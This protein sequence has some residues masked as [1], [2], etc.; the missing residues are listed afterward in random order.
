M[1][2]D[3]VGAPCL[4]LQ[5][6]ESAAI[7]PLQY[8]VAGAGALPVGPHF[9]GQEGA[10][11]AADGGVDDPRPR[12]RRSLAHRQVIP[13]EG[14]GV[15]SLLQHLLGVGVLGHHQQAAGAL[16]QPVDRVKVGGQPP[17]VVIMDQKITQSIRKVAVARVDQHAGGLV[18]DDEILVLVYDVQGPGGGEDA[19]A[20]LQIPHQHRQHLPGPSG[21]VG[22]GRLPVQGNAIGEPLG[23]A[24]QGARE[25][26]A[27]PQEEIHL[28]P[29]Q[30]RG[31]REGEAA[32]R[33]GHSLRS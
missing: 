11:Q 27:A 10:G 1:D 7:C 32:G 5:G 30:V 29:G 17:G 16:V 15:E 12:L 31:H 21:V 4:Q 3:L 23:P 33:R 13:A 9:P 24:D 28:P 26:Q 22:V 14:G 8:P 2:P 18:E 6:Q 19:A 20:A 25:V